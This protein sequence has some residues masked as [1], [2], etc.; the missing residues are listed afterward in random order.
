MTLFSTYYA[1]LY[2]LDFSAI[3]YYERNRENIS[4]CLSLC[5]Y[6]EEMWC[7]RQDVF[8]KGNF[9]CG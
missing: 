1:P 7:K 3:G 4:V 9:L 6:R 5:S 2:A 8:V